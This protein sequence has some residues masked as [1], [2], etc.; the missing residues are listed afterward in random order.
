MSNQDIT[1]R[2]PGDITGLVQ[3][4]AEGYSQAQIDLIKRTLVVV[5]KGMD[6]VRDVTDLELALCFAQAKERRLSP[7]AKQC[8]F[9]KWTKDSQLECFPSWEGIIKQ[10]IDTNDY[11]GHEGPFYS[12]DGV[13]WAEVWLDD[14]PPAAAKVVVWRK[15]V[16]V[17]ITGIA[18][19]RASV[20]KYPSGDPLPRWKDD[21][22]N[23]LGKCALRL[24]FRRAF[25]M[26]IDQPLTPE[27]LKAL[28]TLA[29]LKGM[30][31]AE[32]RP[33]RL[34]EAE[35]IVGREVGSFKELSRTEAS[36]VFEAWSEDVETNPY[37]DAESVEDDTAGDEPREEGGDG[38]SE[39][40]SD[41]AWPAEA[42]E[43][44]GAGDTTL[45]EVR[46]NPAPAT[47]HVVQPLMGESDAMA[48]YR[49]V[50][51]QIKNRKRN[52]AAMA[53]TRE[54]LIAQGHGGVTPEAGIKLLDEA[55]K[56][57]ELTAKLI[58]R[59]LS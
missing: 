41:W 31:G 46:T 5:P 8:Y 18:T 37:V 14:K 28:H 20:R 51:E 19:W 54:V 38:S 36:E 30:K 58:E 6:P 32:G 15:N 29:S 1:V 26:E 9:I 56:L 11:D 24:A 3:E 22:V 53:T 49:D 55:G 7:L 39:M 34:R 43:V 33:Q 40:A 4:M 23:Q 44:A 21:S 50:R 13:T 48:E 35:K 2:G 59:H 57:E 52:A 42:T 27:Q 47:P 10:A 25:P 12:N 16:K 17:P 45:G